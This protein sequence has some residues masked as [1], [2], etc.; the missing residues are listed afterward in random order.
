L[1][2]S[3]PQTLEQYRND[4]N[5]TAR[6]NLHRRFSTN[7]ISWNRWVFDQMRLPACARVLELGAGTGVLWGENRDRLPGGLELVFTDSSEGMLRAAREQLDGVPG[8]EF[9]QMDAARIPDGDRTFDVVIANHMLYHVPDRAAAFSQVVRVLRPSGRLYAATNGA[10]HMEELDDLIGKPEKR[11]L[12]STT[13]FSLESG[14]EQLTPFFG[15]VE[16]RR[17]QNPLAVTDTSAVMA[18]VRS[19]PWDLSEHELTRVAE[20][21]DGVIATTGAFGITRDSG[22]F[23]CADPRLPVKRF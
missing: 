10:S 4:A 3:D 2:G 9:R 5:L 16:L 18:Y 20:V 13:K 7:P 1:S 21:I 8:V 19:L 15:S 6:I 14:A 12:I 22:M 17:H 23:L 11:E